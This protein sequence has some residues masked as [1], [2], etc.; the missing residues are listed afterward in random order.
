MSVLKNTHLN[1]EIVKSKFAQK[2]VNAEG[3]KQLIGELNEALRKWAEFSRTEESILVSQLADPEISYL[4][5]KLGMASS[6]ILRMPN[7]APEF[8]DDLRAEWR[9]ELRVWN[10]LKYG[11]H[12]LEDRLKEHGEDVKESKPKAAWRRLS[13][14]KGKEFLTESE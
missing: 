10:R 6:E 3:K 14:N 9:G 2:D 7:V 12:Q 11:K 1:P 13:K 5:Y 4:N 8:V